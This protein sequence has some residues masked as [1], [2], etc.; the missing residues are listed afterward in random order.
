MELWRDYQFVKFAKAQIKS[1]NSEYS[2]L[3]NDYSHTKNLTGNQVNDLWDSAIDQQFLEANGLNIRLRHKGRK[4]TEMK[5]Y[6]FMVLAIKT[7]GGPVVLIAGIASIINL[8]VILW[9]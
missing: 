9:P 4:L 3:T 1:G 7:Y 6:G 8:V 5:G 2:K